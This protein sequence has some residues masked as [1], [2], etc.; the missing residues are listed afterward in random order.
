MVRVRLLCRCPVTGIGTGARG[1]PR[2]LG[3]KLILNDSHNTGSSNTTGSSVNVRDSGMICNI[4]PKCEEAK[5]R[6]RYGMCWQCQ[7][8][9]W[10][11]FV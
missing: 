4:D 7:L 10:N 1:T 5:W 8:S 11:R 6:R 2:E 9:D 3:V